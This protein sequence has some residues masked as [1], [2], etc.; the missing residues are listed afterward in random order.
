MAAPSYA[1]PNEHRAPTKS[2]LECGWKLGDT[3]A[4][5]EERQLGRHVDLLT[6]KAFSWKLPGGSGHR[7]QD[8]RPGRQA[9]QTPPK[10][11]PAGSA[12]ARAR[13]KSPES[14]IAFP[15]TGL[16]ARPK[17][18]LNPLHRDSAQ[19]QRDRSP[20]VRLFTQSGELLGG[21]LFRAMGACRDADQRSAC[22]MTVNRMN[23]RVAKRSQPVHLD[24][25]S[26]RR[27][28]NTL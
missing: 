22:A 17:N 12:S 14:R 26:F 4:L 16:P 7:Y 21:C 27:V 2:P 3:E 25:V 15:P 5:R 23:S 13:V 20:P 10:A 9:G 1:N 19:A 8:S 6:N 28:G 24:A 18:E 11:R